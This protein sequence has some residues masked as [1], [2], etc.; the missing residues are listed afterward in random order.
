MAMSNIKNTS[1]LEEIGKEVKR[2][3]EQNYRIHIECFMTYYLYAKDDKKRSGSSLL[4]EL[5]EFEQESGKL[6]YNI[7]LSNIGFNEKISQSQPVLDGLFTFVFDGCIKGVFDSKP[8]YT[9]QDAKNLY[10]QYKKDRKSSVIKEDDEEQKLF[11]ENLIGGLVKKGCTVDFIRRTIYSFGDEEQKSNIPSQFTQLNR[12]HR[13]IKCM[14]PRKDY[15][16]FSGKNL[17]SPF[18]KMSSQSREIFDMVD[19]T[20]DRQ[21]GA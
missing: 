15:W 6:E 19:K 9:I 16:W 4:V 10:T 5:S 17:T 14:T 8:T 11:L 18:L 21:I 7:G 12:A 3:L 1:S 13:L 2:I 20:Y